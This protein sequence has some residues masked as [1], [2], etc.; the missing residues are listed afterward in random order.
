[1]LK[2][3]PD[4]VI[5]SCTIPALYIYLRGIKSGRTTPVLST[6][7]FFAFA[8]FLSVVTDFRET[9]FHG[10][11]SNSYNI[12]D[13]LGTFLILVFILFQKNTS[14]K[15]N[16]L[17]KG[18]LIAVF[19]IFILWLISG[20]NILAHLSIQLIMFIA[21]FPMVTHLWKTKEDKEAI[22]WWANDC[23]ISL[24][25][26]INPI[27]NKDLLPIVYGLRS[28]ISTFITVL[29]ILRLKYKIKNEKHI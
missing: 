14:K 20:Q 12:I 21:Y 6:W 26:C 29:L 19:V 10:L 5:I 7:I 2:F 17:E 18:C 9:G 22:S 3:L 27:I 25:G 11:F 1:M 13:A 4:I 15:F 8:T 28:A 24:V 16:K 23:F